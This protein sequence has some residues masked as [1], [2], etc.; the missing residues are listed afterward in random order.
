MDPCRVVFQTSARQ[1]KRTAHRLAEFPAR[2]LFQVT[3]SFILEAL[4]LPCLSQDG[5]VV[6][7]SQWL[8]MVGVDAVPRYAI[9]VNVQVA[10]CILHGA[11][12]HIAL[13]YVPWPKHNVLSYLQNAGLF[14]GYVPD[15]AQIV[16]MPARLDTVLD[17]ERLNMLV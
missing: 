9:H 3:G 11:W 17:G 6:S 2:C 14:N 7:P 10:A 4:E 15:D 1:M 13:P 12:S 8:H 16:R 5:T